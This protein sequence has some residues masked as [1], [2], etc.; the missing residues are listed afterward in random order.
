MK[1]FGFDLGIASIGWAVVDIEK[2]N[3][4]PENGPA[5]NGNIVACGVRCFQEGQPAADRRI[6]RNARRAL[7]HKALRMKNIRKLLRDNNIIDISDMPERLKS[8]D[9]YQPMTL[10][11]TDIDVWE[12]RT[13][14]AFERKLTERETGRILYHLAKH[15]GYD[16]ETY[17]ICIKEKNKDEER[18][19][20]KE[21]EENAKATAAIA[22]NMKSL[23]AGK[24]L[25]QSLYKP[26]TRIRNGKKEITKLTKKGE[27]KKEIVSFY[28][29]S[30]PRSAI[31]NEARM[32]FET[33]KKF[34]NKVLT[35]EIFNAW[36]AIAF[37]QRKF[38]ESSSPLA[39]SIES[40]VGFCKHEKGEPCAPKESPTAELF[41]ALGRIINQNIM[42]GAKTRGFSKE[43]GEKILAKLYDSQKLDFKGVRKL[44]K[45]SDEARFIGLDYDGKKKKKG[46]DGEEKQE[47]INPEDAKFYEMKGWHKLK[48]AMPA[49]ADFSNF[50]ILD[51][52]MTIVATKKTEASILE[53]LQSPANQDIPKEW[54]DG[55]KQ[56]SSAAFIKLSLKALYNVV[57]Y[58]QQGMTYDKAC[59]KVEYDPRDMGDSFIDEN[60]KCGDDFLKRIDFG[61][62]GSRVTSPAVKRTISQFRKVYNAMVRAHGKPGQINIE[63][64]RELKKSA[65]ERKEEIF[66]NRRNEQERADAIA[67]AGERN[68]L[69]YRLYKT[70]DA[71][72]PY[73][74][75][76][77][78]IDG[79]DACEIDHILPYSRSLDNSFNNKV[80]V[81]KTCNQNKMDQTP[82]EWLEPNGEWDKFVNR[83][84]MIIKNPSKK[85]NLFNTTLSNL[86]D[87]DKN[88]F[89]R[90]NACDS[91][92]IANFVVKYLKDGTKND[93]P[94]QVRNGS[95][96]AYM[97]HQ[98]GLDKNR[99]EDNKHHAQDAV[100]I[101]CA[102]Q[103]MVQFLQTWSGKMG[104]A[105][106][107]ADSHKTAFKE[108]W[109]NFR[110]EIIGKLSNVFVSRP[111][112]K[113]A[114]GAA[115]NATLNKQ[116]DKPNGLEI[117]QGRTDRGDMFRCDIFK[118]KGKFVSV[119]VFVCDTIK[120]K[121]DIYYP[122]E[123]DKEGNPK[124][125][126]PKDFVMTLHKDDYVKIKTKDGKTHEGYI[127]QIDHVPNQLKFIIESQDGSKSLPKDVSLFEKSMSIMIKNNDGNDMHGKISGYD[128][129]THEILI[130]GSDGKIYRVAAGIKRDK[131]GKG[132]KYKLSNDYAT[133][134]VKKGITS[135]TITELAKCTVD[136]L[137]NMRETKNL[138]KREKV[139]NIKSKKGR[140]QPKRNKNGLAHPPTDETL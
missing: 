58:M 134:D 99:G 100:V 6:A 139:C 131:N 42:D 15:R 123:H 78:S 19:H 79:F 90:R 104:K 48:K 40:M 23:P 127:T 46:K 105:S 37:R 92:T 102:T 5:A 116:K 77:L 53:A 69:K 129:E 43:E 2:E 73:C 35:D 64:M 135:N 89:A 133:F 34:S 60:D 113:R 86:Y 70:Q 54:R 3:D 1:I 97:R 67:Q 56:M 18:E 119:P 103:G 38:N 41:V 96:T 74:G 108:P 62:L 4:N 31:R 112:R 106:V 29:N 125:A 84:K 7:R 115:H 68:V 87:I 22:E 49:D 126:D 75:N 45:L 95:L 93:I 110:N 117:R 138:E 57:P 91:A 11:N 101:A 28:T 51:R 44:L 47:D 25:A 109:K 88:E 81:H 98:W 30:I 63:V 59:E 136:I 65:Q 107:W 85:R 121:P 14:H 111:P 12:L 114:T 94:V 21:E 39:K 137:G 24:T 26:L 32:I 16:D 61:K 72:C 33:Q 71:K 128:A 66:K 36:E 52:I 27:P 118:Q 50:E 122:C 9:F 17:P 120:E 130:D 82:Y 55:I 132:E 13:K 8:N 80:L 124:A 140:K 83:V 20:S 76:G 10:D